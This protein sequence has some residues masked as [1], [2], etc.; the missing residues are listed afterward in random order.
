[1]S[2]IAEHFRELLKHIQVANYHAC[3]IQSSQLG[4]AMPLVNIF[5]RVENFPSS[6]H[7]M[8]AAHA[9]EKEDF[10]LIMD[11]L[12]QITNRLH[13]CRSELLNLG[14]HNL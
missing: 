9:V 2:D 3:Q 7:A 10:I 11:S 5:D 8:V 4:G 14:V 12:N 13:E 1:M 6:K